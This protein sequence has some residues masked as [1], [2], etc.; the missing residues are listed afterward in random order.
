M[1]A[2]DCD[3]TSRHLQVAHDVLPLLLLRCM[4]RLQVL[5]RR[6]GLRKLLLHCRDVAPQLLL[7]AAQNMAGEEDHVHEKAP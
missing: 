3:G 5:H 6:G 2:R 1:I 7:A 4:L